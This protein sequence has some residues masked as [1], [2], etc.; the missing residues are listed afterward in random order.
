MASG[1]GTCVFCRRIGEGDLLTQGRTAV[2]FADAFPLTPGHALVVPR[3]HESDLFGLT[4]EE[5][6]DLWRL[7]RDVQA[8]VQATHRPDGYNVGVNVGAAGGQTIGHVHVHLIPRYAGDVEDP[9][10]GIRWII[11]ARARYWER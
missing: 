7:L 9:R 4:A 3:R 11:P 1:D 5:Q 6:D 8:R 10:G 2:A